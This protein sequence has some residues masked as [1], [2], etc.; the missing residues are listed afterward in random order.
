[1]MEN[2]YLNEEQYQKANR[3]IKIAGTIVI[4]LGLA[5]LGFGIYTLIMSNKIVEPSMTSSNWFSVSSSKMKMQSMGM[6]MVIPSIFVII[7]GCMIRFVIPNQ[8]QIMA[9]KLQQMI[10]LT[11]EGVE[12]MTPTMKKVA[13]EITKGIKDEY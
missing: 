4:V 13:S 12:E 3:K 7:V 5:L 9:Y 10:P 8:R 11:K 2:K 1:M 6:F